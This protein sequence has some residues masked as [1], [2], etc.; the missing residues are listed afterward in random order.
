MPC[1]NPVRGWRAKNVN[2]SGK[3]SIVFKIDQGFEDLPVEIPCGQCIGCRLERSRQWAIRCVHEASLWENN[4]FI[5]LTYNDDNLPENNSLVLRDFQL[6][7]K[8]LRKKYGPGIR[9]FQCG[10]Y[11]EQN[12][13]PHYHACIFNHDFTDKKVWKIHNGFRL[14]TSDALSKLWPYGYSIIGDVTFESASYVARYIL[15]KITG[16]NSENHYDG[17]KPEFVTMSR[18]PGIGK[19]WY[20]KYKTDLF[21]HDK[22][23]INGKEVTVPKFY[24]NN[25][26]LDD[27]DTHKKLKAIRTK[28]AK[29]ADDNSLKRLLAKETCVKARVKLLKRS[30]ENGE[31]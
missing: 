20:E 11:G 19:G 5:T 16:P 17:R 2:E 27:Q 12:S 24:Q 6:F 15:K 31:T 30:Y 7:M 21:P 1:F 14:Y 26:E 13:R 28:K 29:E 10:E 3:R 23:V 4:C 22:C 25:F 18:R 8:S 9:Y